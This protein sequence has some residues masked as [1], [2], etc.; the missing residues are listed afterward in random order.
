MFNVN[1][2]ISVSLTKPQA[3]ESFM[4]NENP[5][6][7]LSE[8]FLLYSPAPNNKYITK[9]KVLKQIKKLTSRFKIKS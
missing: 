5:C 7:F 4:Q 8:P 1:V 3:T 6:I 9:T 2:S